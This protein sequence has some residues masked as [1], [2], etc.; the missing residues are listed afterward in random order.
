VSVSTPRILVTRSEPG[1]S[2]TAERLTQAGYLP[3]VEPVFAIEPIAA[4]V[5]DF[6]ALAFTSAN[7][8]R[9]FAGLTPRRDIPVFCVGKRTAEAAREAGFSNVI[10][11]NRDVD[12]LAALILHQLPKAARLLHAGNEESRGELAGRLR[13]T[14]HA[15]DFLA[16]FRAVPV[17]APGPTLAAHIAGK[18]AFEAVLIHSPRGA[19]ILAGFAAG[20]L[21]PLHVAAISGA[22]ATPLTMLARRTEIASSPTEQGLLSALARLVSG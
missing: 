15:A 7:G 3:I 1:A 8:A 11:A 16:I 21:A 12:A 20:S 13:A 18:P 9:H 19:A 6:D 4:T 14:G 22:A 17:E 2:E 10:S 5:P